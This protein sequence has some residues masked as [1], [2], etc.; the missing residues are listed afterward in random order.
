MDTSLLPVSSLLKLLIT[1]VKNVRD[2]KLLFETLASTME[3]VVPII[4]QLEKLQK[5]LDPGNK[6]LDFLTKTMRRAKKLVRKCPSVRGYDIFKRREYAKEIEEINQN[7]LTYCN[8]DMRLI[9]RRDSLLRSLEETQRTS[10]DEDE[11]RFL[12][13]SFKDDDVKGKQVQVDQQFSAVFHESLNMKSEADQ[14]NDPAIQES[15]LRCHQEEQVAKRRAREL[16]DEQIAIGLR[17]TATK[18][19]TNGSSSSTY[20]PPDEDEQQVILESFKDAVKGKQVQVDQQFSA[21]LHE[22]L[23]MKKFSLREADQVNDPAI[24]ESIFRSH[25]EEQVAKIRARE[26]HDEQIAI[27]LTYG[28]TERITNASSSSTRALLDEDGSQRMIWESFK[29]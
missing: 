16:W 18:K 24:Q 4:T 14:E 29:K 19:I 7:F 27:G 3:R 15:I 13:E 1:E 10:F 28:E 9:E 23:N 12:M 5:R 6:E 22:S 8:L 21:A 25:Q 17:Y 2:F 11:Q 26:L 20:A